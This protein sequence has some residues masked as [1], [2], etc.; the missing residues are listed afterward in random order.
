MTEA[1]P[2]ATL[3][4]IQRA[5]RVELAKAMEEY[6]RDVYYPALEAIRDWCIANGGH[7]RGKWHNNGLGWSWFYCSRCGG[8]MEITG[9]DGWGAA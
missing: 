8:R 2:P 1:K 9:P 5:R 6:D 7:I 4:A 3:G